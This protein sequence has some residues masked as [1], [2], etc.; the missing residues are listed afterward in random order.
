[1]Q[2]DTAHLWCYSHSI[3]ETLTLSL[4]LRFQTTSEDNPLGFNLE[5][6][7]VESVCKEQPEICCSSVH[8][9]TAQFSS[10]PLPSTHNSFNPFRT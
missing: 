10:F 8:K 7:L 9:N 3:Y 5:P 4:P 1:M 2:T 6:F